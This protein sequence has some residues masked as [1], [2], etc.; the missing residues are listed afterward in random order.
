[1]VCFIFKIY[2]ECQCHF[3]GFDTV[4]QLYRNEPRAGGGSG[5]NGIQGS[6]YNFLRACNYFRI[7]LKCQ[8]GNDTNSV[9]TWLC[10]SRPYWG[11]RWTE[12]TSE[13]LK[14]WNPLDRSQQRISV[15]LSS[16]PRMWFQVFGNNPKSQ[17]HAFHT[18]VQTLKLPFFFHAVLCI[19]KR[20]W[21]WLSAVQ[22][23]K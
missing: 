17:E 11:S 6:S 8:K 15:S 18:V 3:P 10:C 20:L 4:L 9:S 12:R 1:M 2:T 16:S 19:R 14:M 23:G 5:A 21:R 7:S 22:V 13:G